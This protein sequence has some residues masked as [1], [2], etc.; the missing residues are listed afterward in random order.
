MI[1]ILP[2]QAMMAPNEE[3][4]HAQ[5]FHDDY[6]YQNRYRGDTSR[7]EENRLGSE[8][9]LIVGGAET[10]NKASLTC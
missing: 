6:R 5:Q 4:K 7:P 10:E 1:R 2:F 8:I 3:E 9:L